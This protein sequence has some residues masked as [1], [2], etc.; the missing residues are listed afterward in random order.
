MRLTSI[1]AREMFSFEQLTLTELP[2]QMLVV[3]G[4]N[5]SGKTN[6]SRLV[7]VV[8]AAIERAA[9]FSQESYELLVRFGAARRLDAV[10]EDG[11]SIRLGV[12]LTEEWER[13][14]VL[15]FVRAAIMASILR[16]AASNIETSG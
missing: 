8:R 12:A 5:G 4:P 10:P 11:S 15:R 7:E 3:V 1:E 16:N 6:L 2:A 9:T 14:L 13:E